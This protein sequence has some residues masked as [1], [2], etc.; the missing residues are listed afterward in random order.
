[1]HEHHKAVAWRPPPSRSCPERCP[2]PA[3]SRCGSA[4]QAPPL[5]LCWESVVFSQWRKRSTAIAKLH[6]VS[7]RW[8]I[9]TNGQLARPG[10]YYQQRGHVVPAVAD[11]WCQPNITTFA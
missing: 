8:R 5:D 3:L 9:A 1:M 6:N 2:R 7:A 10:R 11:A 4:Y